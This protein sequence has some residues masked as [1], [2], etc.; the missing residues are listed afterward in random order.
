MR[1]LPGGARQWPLVSSAVVLG[2]LAILVLPIFAG[3]PA[4]VAAVTAAFVVF[5][6]AYHRS[7]LRWRS[8][9]ALLLLVILF[10]PIRRYV[11]PGNLPFQL[12]PYRILVA[13]LF[14]MWLTSLLIDPRV[15][16]RRTGLEAPLLLFLAAAAASVIVNSSRVTAGAV[17]SNVIK[18]FT[19]LAS[20][21]LVVYMI[22]SLIRRESDIIFLLK[23]LVVGGAI[24]A[25]LAIVESRT[26]FNVFDHLGSVIPIL[27]ANGTTGDLTRIGRFRAVGPAE[28]PI[29]LSAALAMLV[30]LAGYFAYT[31]RRKRWWL[32]MG[33]I[34]LGCL[35]TV[36]RTGVLMLGSEALVFA[37]LRPQQMKRAWPALLPLLVVVHVALP[38]TLGTLKAS[39]FPKGGLAQEQQG[40][41]GTGRF[42]AA[43]LDPTFAEIKTSPLLGIGYGTRITGF[44]NPE[45]NAITLDD[46]WLDT[47]LETG[48]VGAFAWMWLIVRV[49]RR[50]GSAARRDPSS[51]GW[52]LAALAASLVA[53]GISMITYDAFSFVQVTFF[54]FIVLAFAAR[55]MPSPSP[56]LAP[57]AV[58]QLDR[59]RSS[60][61]LA[62]AMFVLAAALVLFVFFQGPSVNFLIL[63]LILLLIGASS[64]EK[65]RRRVQAP[66]R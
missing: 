16:F 45:A 27:K 11:L 48:I 63:V 59:A 12:E 49:V 34:V 42:G 47:V 55:L 19:F 66:A 32:A 36:S 1:V 24:L 61:A 15:R 25:V 4:E 22:V 53:Y 62:H 31:L 17:D 5:V 14:V 37:I 23:V 56:A 29:A 33:L 35:A 44:N 2:A 52:L 26:H 38:G 18:S 64:I 13:L 50:L 58:P 21:V 60:G 40:Y 30:P 57:A 10:V 28:H 51:R 20:F 43:R 65:A 6:S 39:F 3:I 41:E 46:Q 54:F 7:A 9:L 8:L